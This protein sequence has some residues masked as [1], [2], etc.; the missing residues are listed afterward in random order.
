MTMTAPTDRRSFL[1]AAGAAALAAHAYRVEAARPGPIRVAMVGTG[2]RGWAHLS[3]LGSLPRYQVVALADPTAENLAHAAG[4]APAAKTYADSP[5]LL[6]EQRDLDAVVV[7][8]P[9]FL[10][11]EPTIAALGRGLHVLCEKPMAT[12]VQDATR[13]IEASRKAGKLLHIGFQKRFV[14]T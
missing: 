6:G 4:P 5:E 2:H 10:H 8:T 9:S 13:M 1:K 7:V 12:T 11:A 14:P 3:I